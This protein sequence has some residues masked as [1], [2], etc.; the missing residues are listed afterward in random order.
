MTW[1]FNLSS[2]IMLF[3]GVVL[4]ILVYKVSEKKNIL[5][6]EYFKRMLMAA[7]LWSVFNGIELASD[8]TALKILLSKIE[9]IG[10]TSVMPLWFMFVLSYVKKEKLLSRF[11]RML[12][13]SVSVVMTLLVFTNEYHHLIWPEITVVHTGS[14]LLLKY[15]HGLL[16]YAFTLYCAV[17]LFAGL[18]LLFS[19]LRNTPPLFRWQVL[20]V[21]AGSAIPWIGNTIYIAGISPLPL[22]DLTPIGFIF[23]GVMFLFAI[24]R[25][26]MFDLMPVA[27]SA[28]FDEI[29]VAVVVLDEKKRLADINSAATR[30][31]GI[32]VDDAV[33]RQISEVFHPLSAILEDA[34]HSG[35]T[36][37]QYMEMFGRTFGISLSPLLDKKKAVFGQLIFIRDITDKRRSEV[38]L[39][40]AKEA[41]EAANVTKSQ[42]LANMSHE[43]RTPMNAITGFLEMLSETRLD[44]EQ[45]D[46][47]KEIKS[48]TDSLLFLINDILDYSK[49]EAGKMSLESIPFNLHLLLEDSVSLFTAA[50][51]E[52]GTEIMTHIT[53]GVP[54]GVKGDPVRLRQVLNNVIGNAV[55]FTEKGEVTVKASVISFNDNKVSLQFDVKDT[56]IGISD[57]VKSKLFEV[58]T[59]ADASTTR[60]YGGTGLGLAIS[61]RILD[62]VGGRIEVVSGQEKGSRFIISIELETAEV[63]D[64]VE[65]YHREML[66]HLR[67]FL[68]DDNSNSRLVM[69]DYLEKEGCDVSEAAGGLEAI[70]S[71]EAMRADELPGVMFIDSLLPGLDGLETAGLIAGNERFSRVRLILLH[72][73]AHRSK[74]TAEDSRFFAGYLSK[75]V[76]RAELL[77]TIIKVLGKNPEDVSGRNNKTGSQFDENSISSPKVLLVEDMLANQKLAMLMLKKIGFDIDCVENGQKAV[78]ACIARKYDVILMDCQMPVMDGYEASKKIRSMPGLNTHTPIIAMT[79]NAM[80]GDREKCLAAGMSDYIA[81]PVRSSQLEEC[82]G[83]N[84]KSA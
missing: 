30:L 7:V 48:A 76:R 56:G 6:A 29:T 52:K 69:K 28:I 19:S 17:I 62:M 84:L 58:F 42:F 9:Y 5:S 4:L 60:K 41:A 68:V 71:M 47:L 22:V 20:L 49:I 31:I 10:I 39:L 51:L 50:A 70:K 63:A 33:G 36:G 53:D 82:I 65:I 67:V 40:Q 13:I 74:L 72:T 45:A 12:F 21:I 16:L 38:E 81:K 64:N 32:N 8:D 83:R 55:K 78:E 26:Q 15:G 79:A 73:R 11:G 25:Y 77:S 18:Y 1:N 34:D 37:D 3:S 66:G 46:Y 54:A 24:A 59:Q 43:I 44:E 2:N 80:D 35:E 61:K 57:E 14:G 75:P 27:R 23:T